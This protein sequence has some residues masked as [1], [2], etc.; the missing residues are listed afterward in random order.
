[1]SED[2]A[3]PDRVRLSR[4][5]SAAV[6]AVY[7]AKRVHDAVQHQRADNRAEAFAVLQ[8]A[9]ERERTAKKLY[10][11]HVRT[12]GCRTAKFVFNPATAR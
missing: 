12:H 7:A 8:A 11:R 5:F 3:C 6:V 2:V 9:R 10:L 4:E 1:M